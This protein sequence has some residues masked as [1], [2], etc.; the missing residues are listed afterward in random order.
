MDDLGIPVFQ[1]TS[2]WTF[3]SNKWKKSY[4][5]FWKWYKIPW[6]PS[7]ILQDCGSAAL[8]ILASSFGRDTLSG[9]FPSWSGGQSWEPK[10]SGISAYPRH[11]RRLGFGVDELTTHQIAGRSE[12]IQMQYSE[13]THVCV[14]IHVFSL[15][16]S[17]YFLLLKFPTRRSLCWYVNKSSSNP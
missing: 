6:N 5:M 11:C 12:Q 3:R 14:H 10:I 8:M 1:D 4:E 7:E 17:S 15:T 2:I 13:F 9:D 16:L